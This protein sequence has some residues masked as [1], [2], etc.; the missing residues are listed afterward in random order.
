MP[1]Y[2][3]LFLMWC[4]PFVFYAIDSPQGIGVIS[5]VILNS[6]VLPLIM[7]VILYRSKLIDDLKLN[8]RKQRAIPFLIMIFF[9]FWT[10]FVVRHRLQ[11]PELMTDI[12]WGAFLSIMAAYL[13]NVVYFK[14]SLHAIGMG[15]FIALIIAASFFSLYGLAGALAVGI[16]V[17]GL[18]GTSRLVLNAHEPREVFMGYLVGFVAQFVAFL[19]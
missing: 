1:V 6:I 12:M 17:A 19:T 7:L 4:N 9:F 2:G 13:I 3:L 15:N 8:Q 11:M 10:Y 5:V 18:V 14:I 16:I